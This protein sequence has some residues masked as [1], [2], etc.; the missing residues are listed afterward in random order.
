MRE[1][2]ADGTTRAG[3][4]AALARGDRNVQHLRPAHVGLME[5]M[6]FVRRQLSHFT[7][8]QGAI[9]E[10]FISGRLPWGQQ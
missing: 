9:T 3:P 6:V 4:C 1:G 10:L 7:G 8:A 5:I 2:V